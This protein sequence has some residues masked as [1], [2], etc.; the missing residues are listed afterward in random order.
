MQS[1]LLITVFSGFASLS[2]T[3]RIKNSLYFRI[4]LVCPN[5]RNQRCNTFFFLNLLCVSMVSYLYIVYPPPTTIIIIVIIR[6]ADPDPDFEKRSPC[7][8]ESVFIR[9]SFYFE[10]QKNFRMNFIMSDPE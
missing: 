4:S 2:S 8:C 7:F 10:H 5:S 9:I 6:V 3:S 1:S